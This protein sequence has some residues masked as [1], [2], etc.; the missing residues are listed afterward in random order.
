MKRLQTRLN[1]GE[2]GDIKHPVETRKTELSDAADV[3]RNEFGIDGDWEMDAPLTSQNDRCEEMDWETSDAEPI[4]ITRA[5]DLVYLVPDTNVF[6]H[7][8]LCLENFIDG[9][10]KK[11][12]FQNSFYTDTITFFLVF[13]PFFM[14]RRQISYTG[15]V[16]CSPRIGFIEEQRFHFDVCHSCH[17]IHL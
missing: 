8:L 16:R 5:N 11:D 4:M 17:P 2:H 3:I 15:A 14:H 6:L 10:N 7:S 12:F 9:N 13:P 1:D